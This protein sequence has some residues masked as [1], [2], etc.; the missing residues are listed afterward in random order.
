MTEA[1]RLRVILLY[2]AIGFC[3]QVAAGADNMGFLK[4]IL[5]MILCASD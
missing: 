4:C 3:G 1:A 5:L 2:F